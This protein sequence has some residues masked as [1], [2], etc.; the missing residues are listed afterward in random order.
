MPF[1]RR[2]C[3]KSA[4][5]A[6]EWRSCKDKS[7]RK[8]SGVL[9]GLLRKEPGKPGSRGR[10]LIRLGE[11]PRDDACES[12]AAVKS[13]GPWVAEKLLP[14]AGSVDVGT[15]TVERRCSKTN[16]L[17]AYRWWFQDESGSVARKRCH[18]PNARATSP[19]GWRS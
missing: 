15:T 11:S 5:F 8:S 16:S 19:R 14:A 12:T 18:L 7:P 13:R 10:T 2:T 4:A 17:L 3:Y 1:R 9:E 6:R